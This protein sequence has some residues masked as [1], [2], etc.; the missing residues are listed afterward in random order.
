M[1]KEVY[2]QSICLINE[3]AY[4]YYIKQTCDLFK[5]LHSGFKNLHILLAVNIDSYTVAA[6][7]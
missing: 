4:L 1:K 6:T 7:L 2:N 3:V 5:I